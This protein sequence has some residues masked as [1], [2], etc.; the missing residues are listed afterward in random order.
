MSAPWRQT[1]TGI[2]V[3]MTAPD[4][5]T[6]MLEDIAQSL[7]LQC[8]YTGHLGEP[9]SVAQHSVLATWYAEKD[10]HPPGVLRGI[11]MHDA[12]EAYTGDI[13]TPLKRRLEAIRPGIVHEVEAPFDAAIAERFDIRWDRPA[14]KLYDL[15]MLATEKRDLVQ[16]E[17][18]PWDI[19][20]EITPFGT[21]IIPW[22]W[23]G[24]R[25]E[26]Y[27]WCKKLGIQ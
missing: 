24:A 8:R 22:D 9:Y 6:I 15:R 26:F 19:P 14:I 4:P 17:V 11:L 16:H 20:E 2:A 18:K 1:Y 25:A 12:H 5:R 13:A 27:G 7:T 10:G 23:R 21:R 3:D